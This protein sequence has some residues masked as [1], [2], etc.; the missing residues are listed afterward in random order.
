MSKQLKRGLVHEGA[1]LSLRRVR[2]CG[3]KG[4]RAGRKQLSK[5]L[6]ALPEALPFGWWCRDDLPLRLHQ[7]RAQRDGKRDDRLVAVW[8]VV[9]VGCLCA[10]LAGRLVFGADNAAYRGLP[11]AHDAVTAA[12]HARSLRL[13]KQIRG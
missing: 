3:E 11:P 5:H 2:Q 7:Q 9:H 1:G 6:G 12:N 13:S 4:R 10:G 8:E